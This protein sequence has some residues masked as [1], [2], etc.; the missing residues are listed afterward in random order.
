MVYI[1][2]CVFHSYAVLL[3]EKKDQEGQ[4]HVLSSALEVIL[5][6]VISLHITKWNFCRLLLM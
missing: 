1:V 6:F 2:S 4:S 3:I 5:D